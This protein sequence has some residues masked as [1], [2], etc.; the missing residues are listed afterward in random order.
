[1]VDPHLRRINVSQCR[2]EGKPQ[3]GF[4]RAQVFPRGGNQMSLACVGGLGLVG[5]EACPGVFGAFAGYADD[6]RVEDGWMRLPDRP[7]I[8]FEAQSEL[9]A[10]KRDL[11][12]EAGG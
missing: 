7:G 6:A 8:G 2:A 10:L 12:P 3:L 1:M 11:A 5:C 4:S 9:Y